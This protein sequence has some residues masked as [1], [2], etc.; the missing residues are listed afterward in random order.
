[1]IL[2]KSRFSPQKKKNLPSKVEKFTMSPLMRK[3]VINTQL[4]IHLGI[5]NQDFR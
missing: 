5:E 1:M 4:K 2:L 3:H